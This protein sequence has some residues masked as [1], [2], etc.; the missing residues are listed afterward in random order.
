MKSRQPGRGDGRL[1]SISKRTAHRGWLP[2]IRFRPSPP[3][4]LQFS[5]EDLYQV[6]VS[7]R[8]PTAEV[9]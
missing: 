1:E 3:P 8:W 4:R 6:R 5:G 2:D 7:T 9:G